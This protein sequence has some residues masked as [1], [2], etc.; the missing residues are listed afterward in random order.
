MVPS[1]KVNIAT[2]H[3]FLIVV[4]VRPGYGYS[5]SQWDPTRPYELKVIKV[6][7][8]D[9]DIGFSFNQTFFYPEVTSAQF[10]YQVI[11]IDAEMDSQPFLIDDSIIES[12][13]W[14][15]YTGSSNQVMVT[16]VM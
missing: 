7:S 15:D 14:D 12:E 4:K 6:N 16:T 11:S 9:Y 13:V 10:K 8:I 1:A 5:S 2:K 3:Q